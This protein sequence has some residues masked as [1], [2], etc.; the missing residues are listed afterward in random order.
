MCGTNQT[1]SKNAVAILRDISSQFLAQGD[2]SI[3]GATSLYTSAD[4]KS[5]SG[6]LIGFE[7]TL[8][9]QVDLVNYN[10]GAKQIY[11]AY[12]FE[13]MEGQAKTDAMGLLMSVSGCSMNPAAPGSVA[14]KL[15]PNGIATTN[16]PTFPILT[17]TKIVSARK[18]VLKF[19]DN[20]DFLTTLG[21]HM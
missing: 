18:F 20:A 7:Q 21:G 14:I 11:I 8:L 5:D 4:G 9:Q 12:E 13:Y 3:G 19:R 10:S 15:D 6:Y 16:S 2:D 1:R 17:D